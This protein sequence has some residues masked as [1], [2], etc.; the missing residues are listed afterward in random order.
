M[1][2]G[3]CIENKSDCENWPASRVALLLRFAFFAT[4]DIAEMKLLSLQTS[5]RGRTRLRSPRYAYCQRNLY[6]R[7]FIQCFLFF[8]LYSHARIRATLRN[9]SVVNKQNTPITTNHFFF[10]LSLHFF[11]FPVMTLFTRLFS[12]YKMHSYY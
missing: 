9:C 12:N 10:F 4:H 2:P 8:F 6:T 7:T 1:A 11:R 5:D 3:I